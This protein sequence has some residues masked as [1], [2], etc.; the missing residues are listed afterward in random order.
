MAG[1]DVNCRSC[2]ERIGLRKPPALGQRLSCP[3]CGTRLEVIGVNP[4]ELDWAFDAPIE[5]SS[6]DLMSE[7]LSGEPGLAAA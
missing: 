1:D 6:A 7:D 4:V 2:G 3:R 5:E